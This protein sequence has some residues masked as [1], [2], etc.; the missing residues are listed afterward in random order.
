MYIR[1]EAL[2]TTGYF[3]ETRWGKGYAEENDFCVRSSALGWRHVAACDVFVQHH[4]AVSFEG[5]RAARVHDNLEKLYA[6]YPDY[7][8]R[9]QAFIA[10]DPLCEARS[11]VNLRLMRRAAPRFMLH[12]MH[13]WGGGVEIAVHDL[14][15]RLAKEKEATL[16]LRA[17]ADGS[18]LLALPGGGLPVGYP[19]GTTMAAVGKDLRALGVWHV[20]IHQTVGLPKDVW[21]IAAALKAAYDFTVHDY[22]AVCPRVNFVDAGGAFCAQA[23]LATCEQCVS[24]ASLDAQTR[25]LYLE[26]GGTVAAWRAFHLG[27][28]KKARTVFAPSE[29][30]ARRIGRYAKLPQLRAQPHPEDAIEFRPMAK[31][32]KKKLRV[33]VIGAIGLHKGQRLLLETAAYAKRKKL[34]LEF[35]IVGYTCDDGAYAA[36]DNVKILGAYAQDQLPGLLAASGCTVALFLSIWPETFSYTLSEAWRAGLY[37]VVTDLGAQAE[38]VKREK[39]GIAISPASKPEDVVAACLRAGA[40]AKKKK[41][42]AGAAYERLLPAYYKLK[43]SVARKARK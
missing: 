38:R 8:E 37:P 26:L 41:T 6:L 31:A 36:L 32:P 11:R 19:A 14:C 35:V 22:F 7:P 28:L 27:K 1:R 18:M 30:A 29:D 3:D 42:I 12:V 43:A 40:V 15:A 9:V 33:A 10:A 17:N 20:H 2:R 39:S 16:I 13:G 25:A 23:D 5:D 34:A 24:A 4:G 21:Q